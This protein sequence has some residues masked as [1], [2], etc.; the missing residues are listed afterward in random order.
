MS[1]HNSS[2]KTPDDT[3]LSGREMTGKYA[4]ESCGDMCTEW[5]YDANGGDKLY[6]KSIQQTTSLT[7]T[8][9]MNEEYTKPIMCLLLT[10]SA[11]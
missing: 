3:R 7:P 4:V 5:N 9:K 1:Y 8:Y 10:P 11:E 2:K 6:P